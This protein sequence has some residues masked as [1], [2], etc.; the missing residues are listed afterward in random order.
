MPKS[1]ESAVPSQRSER[2]RDQNDDAGGSRGRTRKCPGKSPSATRRLSFRPEGGKSPSGNI[3]AEE[4]CVVRGLEVAG[5]L[6]ERAGIGPYVLL[7]GEGRRCTIP[8][9]HA[10]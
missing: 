1:F 8:A 5:C 7:G 2:F 10:N 4:K 3:G 9:H 6:R